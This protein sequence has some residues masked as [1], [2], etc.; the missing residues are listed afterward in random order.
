MAIYKNAISENNIQIPGMGK[1]DLISQLAFSFDI[2]S[3]KI[4]NINEKFY[5]DRKRPDHNEASS[6][7]AESE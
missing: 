4:K 6:N 2:E 5:S 1:D 7:D 3:D